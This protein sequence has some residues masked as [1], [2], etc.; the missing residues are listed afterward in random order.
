MTPSEIQVKIRLAQQEAGYWQSLLD[1]KSCHSCK[2]FDNGYSCGLT[3]GVVPPPEV[4]KTGCPK[5]VWD[6]IPF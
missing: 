3:N 2:H 1:K 4:L 6:E 5:W